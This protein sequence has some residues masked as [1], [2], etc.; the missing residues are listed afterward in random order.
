[1]RRFIA[2]YQ[3]EDNRPLCAYLYDLAE[4][5][6]HVKRVMACLPPG[7]EMF[8]AMKANANPRLL[9]EIGAHVHGIETASIGE[10]RKARGIREDIP[11]LFGG[12]GKTDGELAEAIR[13][14]VRHLHVESLHELRRVEHIAAS[15]GRRASVLL[16]V[17]LR[18]ALPA[19]TLQ[20]G[21]RPTQ[22]GLDE[23]LIGQAAELLR[24]SAHVQVE[25]FHLHSVSNQLDA[26]AH[27]QLMEHYIAKVKEW[28]HAFNLPV[29]T[30][31]VG[32]GIGV[33]YRD[34]DSPFEWEA[35]CEQLGKLLQEKGDPAW[36]L[37]F[38]CGRF[39]V[40]GCGAYA[41][42][43]LDVKENHGEVFAIV[44]GGTHHF[45]LPA[46]WQHNHPFV[47][48]A[49]REWPYP[50]P[51]TGAVRRAVTIAGQ[52]CTPKDVLARQVP[53]E[54]IRIGDVVLF[55]HAGA[56][57]WEISHHEFLS[58]PHPEMICLEEDSE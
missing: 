27:L 34:L 16:R 26:Q 48:V 50:F 51:R 21:G 9:R 25:G 49:R 3:A 53:V 15:L 47:I 36:K 30:V 54:E 35:F 38:E 33:N 18:G 14:Q 6:R 19:A 56:Y 4:L 8:Y 57:G 55:R 7:C 10:V 29:R 22:F 40:A 44:R 32:G 20:M 37:V 52:L 39:L 58:H 17:N 42:E 43:V 41:A 46:S 13:L 12:P 31:N 23:Q 11:V 2:S 1:M 24:G 28:S 5:R 45:R